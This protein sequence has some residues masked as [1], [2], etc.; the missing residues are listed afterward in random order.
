M[1]SNGL[2]DVVV[3]PLK[4]PWL[5]RLY[6]VPLA[7][8]LVW[9]LV[10]V[11]LGLTARDQ[12]AALP[13]PSGDPEVLD[14]AGW[15]ALPQACQSPSFT[16][17]PKDI[18]DGAGVDEAEAAFAEHGEVSGFRVVG[19]EDVNFWGDAQ[20][21]N[22]SQALGR[23]PLLDD[24]LTAW[25]SYF[26]ELDGKLQAD[27]RKL[28]IVVAPAKW[29]LY[30]E[31]L[32]EW[33][34]DYQGQTHYEQFLEHAGDLPVADVRESM[35][36][37]KDRAPVFSKVNSH[38]TPYGAE[39]AWEQMVECGAALYPDSVWSRLTVPQI[40]GVALEEA[41]N[42]FTEHGDTTKPSDWSVPQ[43]A[44]SAPSV[45]VTRNTDAQ[46]ST[47]NDAGH[48]TL[49][50]MPATTS[51]SEGSG[52][53]LI[54]RDST[55]DALSERWAASFANTCQIRHNLD[56]EDRPD[57]LSEAESCDAETVVYVFTERYFSKYPPSL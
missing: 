22:F 38:W 10:L 20:A 57:V 50:D 35:L 45:E 54:V 8:L 18:W 21:S 13:V 14:D 17:H 31:N 6:Y 5:R 37:A 34:Q 48:I 3:R 36:Q 25:L 42:E 29:E 1:S 43:Y 30:R 16:A 47:S 15:Q 33:T 44:E 4:S 28:L 9:S 19:T 39:S 7:I 56:Y 53:A 52:K 40:T 49:D 51:N 11:A 12:E 55:G 23:A 2:R 27:G 32:P 26:K 24:Q 46:A 41:P